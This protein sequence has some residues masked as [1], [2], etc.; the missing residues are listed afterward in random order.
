MS[1]LSAAAATAVLE[2]A[3]ALQ[4]SRGPKA[5][6]P[7]SSD[8]STQSNMSHMLQQFILG[9]LSHSNAIRCDS[10]FSVHDAAL[11]HGP[12]RGV[13]G[14]FGSGASS[15]RPPRRVYRARADLPGVTRSPKV[16]QYKKF[17]QLHYSLSK[18]PGEGG[19]FGNGL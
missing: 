17:S 13:I 7:R 11:C 1:T 15:Y 12:D 18:K 4:E 5:A 10:G 19:V 3:P 2:A 9:P 16:A 6:A 8:N 14:L